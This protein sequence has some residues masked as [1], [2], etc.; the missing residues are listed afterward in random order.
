[1][2]EI[3]KLGWST[4]GGGL[5]LKFFKIILFLAS[6]SSHCYVS[7]QNDC[8][9]R[10]RSNTDS[11]CNQ[12]SVMAILSAPTTSRTVVP[13]KF[14][15]CHG[16]HHPQNKF[17]VVRT[18]IQYFLGNFFKSKF[19]REIITLMSHRS[20]PVSKTLVVRGPSVVAVLWN[21]RRD[22]TVA[23]HQQQ[24]TTTTTTTAAAA[25]TTTTVLQ[26][27]VQDYLGEPVPEETLTHP[28]S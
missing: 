17:F 11:S 18:T 12:Q 13:T 20:P 1:M 28:P 6:V 2:P 5:G 14:N 7:I 3:K 16:K 24:Q 15:L 23:M 26:P 19:P 9:F 27:F 10:D 25:T 8:S 21:K 22:A 4:N